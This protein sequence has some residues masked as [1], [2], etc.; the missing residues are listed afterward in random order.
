MILS[1]WNQL[2]VDIFKTIFNNTENVKML[3]TYFTFMW[4]C[5]DNIWVKSVVGEHFSLQAGSLNVGIF[6]L[7]SFSF[8]EYWASLHVL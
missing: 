5:S 6:S 4:E 3:R 7:H 2:I 8:G 1:L